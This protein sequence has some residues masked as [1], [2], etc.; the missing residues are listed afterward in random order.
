LT[1]F[2]ATGRPPPRGSQA[3]QGGPAKQLLPLERVYQEIAILKKLD[4][5]NVVK[6]IEVGGVG[7]YWSLGGV[8]EWVGRV[9]SAYQ[10][11]GSKWMRHWGQNIL[12]WDSG[13]IEAV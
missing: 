11:L 12:G 1:R 3:T 13:G 5:V 7:G 9:C 10:G 4:H 6:L 8:D 2:L